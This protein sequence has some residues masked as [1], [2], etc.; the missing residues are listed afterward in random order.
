MHLS[1]IIPAYNEAER[2]GGTLEKASA[3]F[4]MQPYE[5]EIIVVDDGSSDGTSQV[6]KEYAAK[7]PVAL[8]LETLPENRGK[9]YAVRAGMLQ[10]A[11]GNY[12]FFY[13]ADAS[14]PIE[15]LDNCRPLF[16]AGADIIIGSR[17]L[18]DSVIQVRQAW[19]REYMGRCFNTLEKVLGVTAFKDTQCGFKGFTATA[20]ECCFSRQTIN[21]FSFDAELLYIAHKHG[22]KV[23]ELPVRWLNSPKSRVNPL[24][25]A[26]RMFFDL[27]VIRTNDLAGRYR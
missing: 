21:R 24:T 14:T 5:A 26:S 15:E 2:I 22:L 18:P 6:V 20:A 12:R 13:D 1:L 9:G 11:T 23:M 4:A 17:A 10:R 7:S 16:D 8:L 19:Y 3:Y 25:D 27:L